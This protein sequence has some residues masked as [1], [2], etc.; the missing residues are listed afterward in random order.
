M[1]NPGMFSS[2]S[3]EWRTPKAVYQMLEAE[4]GGFDLDPCSPGA[5][6]GLDIA[7]QG[8]VFVNP[9]YGRGILKWVRK[10]YMSGLDGALVVMLLPSRTDTE[11]WHEFVM[12]ATHVRYIRGRLKFSEHNDNAPFPS[13]IVIFTGNGGAR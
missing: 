7:W 1:I 2:Q 10:G 6:N 12:K 13:C 9:P 5:T 11:W 4:F 8:K 3:V